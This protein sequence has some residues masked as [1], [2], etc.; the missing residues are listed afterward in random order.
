MVST[1]VVSLDWQSNVVS[2]E[3]SLTLPAEDTT[4]PPYNYYT[5]VIHPYERKDGKTWLLMSLSEG[6][7]LLDVAWAIQQ[8]L[9]EQ[10]PVLAPVP[11][12]KKPRVAISR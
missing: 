8:S 5:A 1:Q 2:G 10:M 12:A 3:T 4:S 7:L 9:T 6:I 11:R